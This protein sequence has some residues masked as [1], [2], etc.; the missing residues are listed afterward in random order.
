MPKNRD[1]GPIILNAKRPGRIIGKAFHV[2]Y[3]AQ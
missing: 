2:E 1:Y 3:D